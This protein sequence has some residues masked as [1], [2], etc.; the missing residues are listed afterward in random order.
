MGTHRRELFERRAVVARLAKIP[1]PVSPNLASMRTVPPRCTRVM[2]YPPEIPDSRPVVPLV[3]RRAT[4]FRVVDVVGGGVAHCRAETRRQPMSFVFGARAFARWVSWRNCKPNGLR[5]V[6]VRMGMNAPRRRVGVL[7]SLLLGLGSASAACT[8]RAAAHDD[9]LTAAPIQFGSTSGTDVLVTA[10]GVAWSADGG[11][12]LRSPGPGRAFID[13][14][15]PLKKCLCFDDSEFLGPDDAWSASWSGAGGIVMWRTTDGGTHWSRSG[16]LAGVVDGQLDGAVI[17]PVISFSDPRHGL[18]LGVG[19]GFPSNTTDQNLVVALWSTR[20]GGASWQR[21]KSHDLPMQGEV[22]GGGCGDA[23]TFGITAVTAVAATITLESCSGTEPA[24]WR[25]TDGGLNWTRQRIPVPPGGWHGR[26]PNAPGPA[27]ERGV[28]ALAPEF[29]T[30][31]TGLMAVTP[32]PG[33]ILVYRTTNGGARWSYASSLKTGGANELSDFDA[34]TATRWAVPASDGTW[35]TQDGGGVWSLTRAS[36]ALSDPLSNPLSFDANGYGVVKNY[37]AGVPLVTTNDGASWQ[38]GKSPGPAGQAATS[39]SFEGTR[40]GIAALPGGVALTA[41]GGSS[42]TRVR[43]PLLGVAIGQVAL[44]S[45]GSAWAV[46]TDR[47]FFSADDGRTWKARIEPAAGPVGSVQPE[48]RGIAY[49]DD[50]GGIVRTSDGGLTWSPVRMPVTAS[51]VVT[52]GIPLGEPGHF[53]CFSSAERGY[54]YDANWGGKSIL[55]TTSD[56]GRRWSIVSSSEPFLKLAGCS[57]NA[58]WASAISGVVLQYGVSFDL[59]SSAGGRLPWRKVLDGSIPG[60][61]I[62][63]GSGTI[64]PRGVEHFSYGQ[65]ISLDLLS[66]FVAWIAGGCWS[67]GELDATT[68]MV[69]RDGGRT[70]EQPLRRRG[71]VVPVIG[72]ASSVEFVSASDGWLLGARPSPSGSNSTVLLR[73]SDGGASWRAVSQFGP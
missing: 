60:A 29:V 22:V 40:I 10:G 27:D 5:R 4:G 1:R 25:T 14:S 26:S 63:V 39:V 46:T 62:R 67:C 8:S 56:G 32:A 73:T 28:G 52:G 42:W 48:G 69:T 68:M 72:A 51:L 58:L 66:P 34:L 38:L 53:A 16:E 59:F 43:L 19:T 47:L 9:V 15:P 50:G 61:P 21:V 33:R 49:A 65:L 13:V 17:F 35:W 11:G 54:L 70:W 7:V 24:L 2:K 45:G 71:G 3:G 20:D 36:I 31:T 23:G 41:D 6:M 64:S 12:V 30:A 57:G 44:A 37:D 55:Y 18:V